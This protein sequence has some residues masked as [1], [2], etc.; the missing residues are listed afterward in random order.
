MSRAAIHAILTNRIYTGKFDW[1]EKVYQ[2]K[3]Q[4]LITEELWEKVQRL[5][6]QRGQRKTRFVTHAF[7]LSGL[8]PARRNSLAESFRPLTVF[9][10]PA[11]A[12]ARKLR[13]RMQID[14]R[15]GCARTTS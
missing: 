6:R 4:P 2:G 10:G 7:A 13:K 11:S 14:F 15:L 5:L 3:Y 12:A 1:N 9:A 8:I